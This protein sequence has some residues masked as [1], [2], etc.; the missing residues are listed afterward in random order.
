M[1]R[2]C[3]PLISALVC[4]AAVG[5][6]P[7]SVGESAIEPTFLAR[8]WISEAELAEDESLHATELQTI[9]LHLEQDGPGQSR[10]A[11]NHVRFMLD[12]AREFSFCIPENHP[13][14]RQVRLRELGGK[15]QGQ[16]A[17]RTI[18]LDGHK[19]DCRPAQLEPGRYELIIS[20]DRWS[21]PEGGKTAFLLFMNKV[22]FFNLSH[23]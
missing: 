13:H 17:H 15:G 21:L 16:Q 22:G 14:L 8:D 3:S 20:H 5:Y 11:T 7:W 2:L 6:T 12:E 23:Y 9:V 1:S 19:R 10:F 4:S 18:V